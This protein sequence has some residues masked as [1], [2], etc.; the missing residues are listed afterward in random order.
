MRRVIALIVIIALIATGIAFAPAIPQIA[1]GFCGQA[2]IALLPDALQHGIC[3]AMPQTQFPADAGQQGVSSF[4]TPRARGISCP[5]T[6]KAGTPV[7]ISWSCGASS[8]FAVAGFSLADKSATS[9]VV[10]PT[11]SSSVYGIQC[12]NGYQDICSIDTAHPQVRIWADP[13]RVRLGARANIFWAA[14]DARSCHVTGPSFDETGTSGGSATVPITTA[15]TF[16][17]ACVTN[18]STTI[19]ASVQVDFAQ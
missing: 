6:A 2:G 12:A 1:R 19:S 18:A 15:T 17:A 7:T 11:A 14:D 3:D 9:A 16:T 10:T 5:L 8:L 4:T 13:P